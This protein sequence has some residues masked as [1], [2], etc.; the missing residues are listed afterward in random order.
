MPT[1]WSV[2]T[3][4]SLPLRTQAARTSVPAAERSVA[5]L[6]PT[7]GPESTTTVSGSGCSPQ[8]ASA[9]VLSNA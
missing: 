2:I 8:A 9:L 6:V 7:T 5:P 1:R 3:T 4:L